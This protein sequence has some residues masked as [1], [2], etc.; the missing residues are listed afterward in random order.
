MQGSDESLCPGED[1]SIDEKELKSWLI[2]A[3]RSNTFKDRVEPLRCHKGYQS[4]FLQKSRRKHQTVFDSSRRSFP[5]QWRLALLRRRLTETVLGFV[6]PDPPGVRH[7]QRGLPR[8]VRASARKGGA[9]LHQP[10][11]GAEH[12]ERSAAQVP[13]E[14]EAR[15]KTGRFFGVPWVW[16]LEGRPNN[17]WALFCF[18]CKPQQGNPKSMFSWLK[19]QLNCF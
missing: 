15:R 18:P 16:V 11:G 7:Q 10:P 5:R 2:Q 1:G 17:L 13:S 6:P 8:G 9:R 14:P 3:R 12:A 4:A 19:H